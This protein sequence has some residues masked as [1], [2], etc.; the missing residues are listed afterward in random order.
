MA[1]TDDNYNNTRDATLTAEHRLCVRL[2][3]RE[4]GGRRRHGIHRQGVLLSEGGA[5][6]LAPVAVCGTL[7]VTVT[8]TVTVS[9]ST[10]CLALTLSKTFGFFFGFIL[11]F[12]Q[13]IILRA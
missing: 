6:R 13:L 10:P 4:D 1:W 5:P 8:V 3:G 12:Y 9:S 2:R 7:T 11:L